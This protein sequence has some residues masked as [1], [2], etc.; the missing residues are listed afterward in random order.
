[1]SPHRAGAVLALNVEDVDLAN[2]QA[3]PAPF[4]RPARPAGEGQPRARAHEGDF[5]QVL[6]FEGTDEADVLHAAGAWTAEHPYVRVIATDWKG[7]LLYEIDEEA[8]GAPGFTPR[9]RFELIVERDEQR[10]TG[11]S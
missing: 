7:D 8:A 6:T 1:M 5:I 9:H 2:R 3:W 10:R 4:S 11:R